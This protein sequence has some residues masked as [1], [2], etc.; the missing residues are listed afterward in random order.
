[1]TPCPVRETPGLTGA[2]A[3]EPRVGHAASV[4][5]FRAGLRTLWVQQ[6]ER[7]AAPC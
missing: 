7:P 6:R 5:A 1:M 2:E 3:V 4:P